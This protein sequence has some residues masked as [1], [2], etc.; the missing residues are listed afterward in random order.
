VARRIAFTTCS[1]G[2]FTVP[3]FGPIFAPSMDR[4]GQK[5]SLPQSSQTVS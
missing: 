4:M 5:S 2:S 1:A 3:D